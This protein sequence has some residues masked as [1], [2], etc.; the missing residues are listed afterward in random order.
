MNRSMLV[1][2]PLATL[3]GCG[4]HSGLPTY[5]TVPGFALTAESGKSFG[6]A[7]LEG[8]VWVANFFFT[9]CNG[10]CPRMSAQLHKLQGMIQDRREVRLVSISIDPKHDTPE[11][12][13]AYAKRWKADPVRWRFL[14]GEP[15]KI[16]E[17]SWDT[18]HLS[19]VGGALQ[20]STKFAL[21]DKKLQIR[22]YYDSLDSGGLAE[23]ASDISK[24]ENEIF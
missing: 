22:G 18:F 13:A 2:L 12:V 3:A 14:T 9:T 19:E 6:S 20:H 4:W 24:L 1:L 17:L 11:V 10:P 5:G 15:E 23:L 7:D 8:H 16:K 21:V